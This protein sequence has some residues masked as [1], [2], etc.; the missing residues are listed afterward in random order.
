MS[1]V[2]EWYV[3]GGR[4]AT[5][6]VCACQNIMTLRLPRGSYYKP[7]TVALIPTNYKPYLQHS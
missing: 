2:V 7:I 1:S 6:T 5:A 4:A 3:A